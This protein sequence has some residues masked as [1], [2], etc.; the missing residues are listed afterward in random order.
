MSATLLDIPTGEITPA[1]PGDTL[2]PLKSVWVI[3]LVALVVRLAWIGV[4][5]MAPLSDSL[6]YETFARNM[7]AG[8]VHGWVPGKPSAYWPVGASF[9]Y[10]VAYRVFGPSAFGPVLFNLI[11][12]MGLVAVSVAVVRRLAGEGAAIATGYILALWPVHIEFMTVLASE[13]F[14]T[15][16]MMLGLLCWLKFREESWW[17]TVVAGVAFAA[18]AY[19]RPTVL[20]VPVILTGVHF[21]QGPRRARIF[22]GAACLG[23]IM[24][25]LLAPWSI[26]NTRTFGRFVTISTNAGSNF[27]MGN[28]PETTGFYMKPPVIDPTNEAADNAA[29]G[30]IAR[31][32]IAEHPV[33]FVKR[34][35]I[36]AVRL[37]ERQTIGFAWNAE[38][39]RR[40]APEGA[41]PVIKVVGQVYWMAVLGAAVCGCVIMVRRRGPVSTLA[42][43]MI[44]I[45][46]YFVV[47]HAVI[48]IQDR[49]ILPATPMIGGLAGIAVAEA[50]DRLRSR[51]RRRSGSPAPV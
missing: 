43:P 46:A 2:G 36:K 47:V 45:W 13:V 21:V 18:A 9:I 35:F 23:L 4:V 26:R 7:A 38:G 44:F 33:A 51:S 15:T 16:F 49:Y 48:V 27:W 6:A 1:R 41:L 3:L 37:H 5:P 32:Y 19:T 50:V 17:W 29:L 28:N 25:V 31:E 10:S 39:L 24:A 14:C 20:L 12:G 8:D 22:L 34:T 30:K 11:A 42:N 40:V